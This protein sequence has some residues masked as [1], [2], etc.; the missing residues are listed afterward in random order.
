MNFN[1]DSQILRWPKE[2]LGLISLLLCSALLRCLFLT[3]K[4]PHFDEGVYGFFVQE[5]WRKGFFPY[6]PSNFH[7]PA[8]YY[9]LQLAE[10]IFGR[11]IFGFRLMSGIFSWLT[12]VYVWRMNKFFGEVA[13]WAALAIAVSPSAVF[14]SRY[15]M[16]ES[17]FVLFQVLFVHHYFDFISEKNATSACKMGIYAALCFANKET[18]IIFL[19]CFLFSALLTE[20]F[21]KKKRFGEVFAFLK[22]KDILKFIFLG[23][24]SASAL[25]FFLFSGLFSEPVRVF[26]FFRA[27]SFWTKTGT[28]HLSGHEKPFYYWFSLLLR[29]EWPAFI[30]L[31]VSPLLLFVGSKASRLFSFFSLGTLAA[32]AIIPYKTPWCILGIVWPL[33]FVTGFAMTEIRSHRFFQ[34]V[35]VNSKSSSEISHVRSKF[36]CGTLALI[37]CFVSLVMCI[38]L[39]FFYFEDSNEPYVYVQSSADVNSISNVIK[40]KEQTAS[41]D[42]NM[43]IIVGLKVAWPFP[44]ILSDFT[45]VSYR[46][47]VAESDNGPQTQ[48]VQDQRKLVDTADVIL[49]DLDDSAKIEKQLNKKYFKSPFKLRDSYNICS[50]YF[51]AEKFQLSELKR[52]ENEIV[53]GE[54]SLMKFGVVGEKQ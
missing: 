29:Y 18:T 1:K 13:I 38:R 45:H 28:Q 47:I 32:Y 9:A 8:Y 53:G 34:A 7:G 2:N 11:G 14:Y 42:L 33:C 22:D 19:F 43:N 12:I 48:A 40:L 44:W 10:Q 54:A 39:N 21:S 35:V 23:I 36:I 46:E 50:V 24:L 52:L 15:A 37:L 25:T 6:D 41:E 51:N 26:D 31:L 17:M 27:Y 49:V 20:M 4:S 16:H 30:G 3:L 5:I